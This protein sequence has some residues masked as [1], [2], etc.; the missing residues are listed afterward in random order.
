MTP[1]CNFWNLSMG[2]C[3]CK[4]Q[5]SESDEDPFTRPV[6]RTSVNS[7]LPA[8]DL[9]NVHQILEH[10]DPVQQTWGLIGPMSSA[11]DKLVLETLAVI[12]TLVDK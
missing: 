7:L 6:P 4:E 2:L 12:R 1:Q 11:V 3:V 8:G 5:Q 9:A 10:C